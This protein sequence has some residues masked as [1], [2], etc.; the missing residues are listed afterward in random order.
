MGMDMNMGEC[1]M[2]M[3][4]HFDSSDDCV[5]FAGWKINNDAKYI[6]TCLCLF[7]LCIVR[8][9]VLYSQKYFEIATLSGKLV[10]FWPTLQRL[11]EM[12]TLR[13][14]VNPNVNEQSTDLSQRMLRKNSANDPR[15]AVTLKLR[16]TDVALYGLALIL[17][18]MTFNAGLVMVVIAGYCTGRFIF[19]RRTQ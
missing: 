12:S 11:Q 13:S 16:L 8:E 6:M 7:A 18:V 5:L 14:V 9:F 1:G 3:Y 2:T 4:F 10:P 19:H 15:K 17:V